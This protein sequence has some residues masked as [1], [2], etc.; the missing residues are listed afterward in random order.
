MVATS[1]W[2]IGLRTDAQVTSHDQDVVFRGPVDGDV[3]ADDDDAFGGN[4]AFGKGVALADQDVRAI[5]RF[6][7]PVGTA[8]F[9]PGTSPF[10]PLLRSLLVALGPLGLALGA[11]SLVL[12]PAKAPASIT[13][14]DST[15][16]CSK[17]LMPAW[18]GRGAQKVPPSRCAL[19]RRARPTV[20]R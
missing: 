5:R 16:R 8:A 10:R 19:T 13:T 15:K 18:D 7:V 9:R 14:A 6:E 11:T 12:E 1:P 3:V 17:R 20:R 2:I 4:R